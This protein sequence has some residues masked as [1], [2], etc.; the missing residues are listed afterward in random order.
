[1]ELLRHLP[2]R[3]ISR[4]VFGPSP[5]SCRL[6]HGGRH[7][8]RREFALSPRHHFRRRLGG[9]LRLV[10][11]AAVHPLAAP[12]QH[13]PSA[14]SVDHLDSHPQHRHYPPPRNPHRH[15]GPFRWLGGRFSRRIRGRTARPARLVGGKQRR[16]STQGGPHRLGGDGTVRLVECGASLLDRKSTR[17]NSS[18]V[19]NSYA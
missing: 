12:P 10:R 18:H 1:D 6:S 9:G 15:V 8:I 11:L 17:L 13:S 16:T 3:P 2:P 4:T 5:F 19:K 14:E 7:R